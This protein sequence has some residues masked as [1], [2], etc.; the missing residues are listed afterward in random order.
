MNYDKMALE[1]NH[2]KAQTLLCT[3]LETKTK[4]RNLAIG[5]VWDNEEVSPN[6]LNNEEICIRAH[7]TN[8]SDDVIK[9][10][11]GTMEIH[12]EM[13]PSNNEVLINTTFLIHS[14]TTID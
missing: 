8:K 13:I 3:K 2:C 12:N 4:G 7:I 10:D 5:N 6:F 1:I 9:I 14:I 11:E